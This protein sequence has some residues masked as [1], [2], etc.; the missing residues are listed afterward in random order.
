M[1]GGENTERL[2]KS[3]DLTRWRTKS[4]TAKMD[5]TE[6]PFGPSLDARRAAGPPGGSTD[7]RAQKGPLCVENGPSL[8]DTRSGSVETG[9]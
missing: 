6:L 3:R 7:L 5:T 1:T 9:R 8:A 2:P 4:L